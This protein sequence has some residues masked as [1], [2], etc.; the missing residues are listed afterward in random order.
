MRVRCISRSPK[1]LP[2]DIR[3]ERIWGTDTKDR[4]FPLRIGKEYVVYG[5][6]I[7]LGHVWYYI[8]D[9]DFVYYP[10]WNPSSLFEISDSSLPQFWRIGVRNV[11]S[12]DDKVDFILSFPEWV[13]DRYF[14]SKLV[15]GNDEE[16]RIFNHYREMLGDIA[17]PQAD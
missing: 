1:D 15:D 7:W 6:T 8:C 4:Y 5:V 13:D 11:P 10:I 16:L 17:S 12:L 2:K 14:Y 3:L 9:E